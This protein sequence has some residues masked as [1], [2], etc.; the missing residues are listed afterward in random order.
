MTFPVR[1]VALAL[2]ML[3]CA[4]PEAAAKKL[5]GAHAGVG[6]PLGPVGTPGVSGAV[7]AVLTGSDLEA[8]P[9]G[10]MRVRGEILGVYSP[11]G[12]AGALPLLLADGGIEAGRFSGFMTAGVEIMG[13]AWRE[14]FSFFTGFGLVGGGGLAL[15]VHERV[16]LELRAQVVWLPEFSA[17]RIHEPEE[18]QDRPLLLFLSG[19]LGLLIS[20]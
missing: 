19:M 16:T 13:F 1:P 9:A 3:L 14:G 12:S 17:A 7:S 15:R 10:M 11:D 18:A 5:Y 20:A 6:L 8:G 4:A 2:G